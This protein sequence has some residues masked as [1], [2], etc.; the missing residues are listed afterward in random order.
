MKADKFRNGKVR[1]MSCFFFIRTSS[2]MEKAL[3]QHEDVIT[4]V[5]PQPAGESS[6]F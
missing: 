3:E 4:F 5:L 1:A 6:P 2:H